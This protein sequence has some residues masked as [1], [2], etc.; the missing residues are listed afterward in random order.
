MSAW[1][2][3]NMGIFG[4]FLSLK[5]HVV[6]SSVKCHLIGICHPSNGNRSS[7]MTYVSCDLGHSFLA[8]L[9]SADQI[10]LLS[11][12]CYCITMSLSAFIFWSVLIALIKMSQA[13]QGPAS[14][15]P[16]PSPSTK[17]SVEIGRLDLF[18]LR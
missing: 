5:C 14:C 1:H 15:A 11:V 8:M 17:Q 13:S 12:T 7:K 4:P 6:L 9:S 3:A 16:R 18:L 2:V 10:K